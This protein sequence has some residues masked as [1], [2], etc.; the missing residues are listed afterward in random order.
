MAMTSPVAE[1]DKWADLPRRPTLVD[2][3]SMTFRFS[4]GCDE[5]RKTPIPLDEARIPP[6]IFCDPSTVANT[7]LIARCAAQAT[8]VTSISMAWDSIGGGGARTNRTMT[9]LA[10]DQTHRCLLPIDASTF[11]CHASYGTP[12]TANDVLFE[13]TSLSATQ[14]R[15]RCLN[16]TRCMGYA[17]ACI[18]AG[19]DCYNEEYLEERSSS[20]SGTHRYVF[21]SRTLYATTGAV[22][23]DVVCERMRRAADVL[24]WNGQH[25]EAQVQHAS[26]LPGVLVPNITFEATFAS[27]YKRR[28]SPEL[29]AFNGDPTRAPSSVSTLPQQIRKRRW[30]GAQALRQ[31]YTVPE[32]QHACHGDTLQAVGIP[33]SRDEEWYSADSLRTYLRGTGMNTALTGT[34]EF[35]DRADN[36]SSLQVRND[37]DHA[38]GETMLDV[39]MLVGVAPGAR[40]VLYKDGYNLEEN[41]DYGET[42]M[43][44]DV[45]NAVLYAH[46]PP[47]VLS[48]SWGGFYRDVVAKRYA[49][50]KY[51]ALA[52]MGVSVIM[53]S[54][55]QG[56]V[57]TM[58]GSSL[59]DGNQICSRLRP[60]V[61]TAY[62]TV[63]G[64][65][66]LEDAGPGASEIVCSIESGAGITSGGGFDADHNRTGFF[67]FQAT[68]VE[69]YLANEA[70]N[71]PSAAQWNRQGRAYPDV[72]ALAHNIG[73]HDGISG[74]TSAAAPMFAGM[75]SLVNDILSSQGKPL[76]G[77]LA[78]KLYHV[79]TH[80]PD[81]FL[82]T[83]TGSNRCIGQSSAATMCCAE[84]FSA[85]AG[86]DPATGLGTPNW[87]VLARHLIE[88][89]GG[90]A[91]EEAMNA[92]T[93]C[94][95]ARDCGQLGICQGIASQEARCLH[96]PNVTHRQCLDD[97]HCDSAARNE[98]AGVLCTLEQCAGGVTAT[99]SSS[100]CEIG[101]FG[102]CC[103][104]CPG[105]ALTPC[106]GHGNCTGGDGTR[107]FGEHTPMSAGRCDCV[108]GFTGVACEISDPYYYS[109]CDSS[110]PVLRCEPEIPLRSLADGEIVNGTTAGALDCVGEQSPEHIFT[111]TLASET[112]VLFTFGCTGM[113]T[114]ISV[115]TAGFQ[116]R[117]LTTTGLSEQ[118]RS[119]PPGQYL[120]VVEGADGVEGAYSFAL[121]VPD[122]DILHCDQPASLWGSDCVGD[123]V[124]TRRGFHAPFDGLYTIIVCSDPVAGPTI[125]LNIVSAGSVTATFVQG[126]QH[127]A[128]HTSCTA[129]NGATGYGTFATVFLHEGRHA[130][131]IS[132]ASQ[133]ASVSSAE[134]TI[135][136]SCMGFSGGADVI[137]ALACGETHSGSMANGTRCFDDSTGAAA[138]SSE[139]MFTID[140]PAHVTVA[141]QTCNSSFNASLRVYGQ[142]FRSELSGCNLD[143]S[144]PCDC[145][146]GLSQPP[147]SQGTWRA[148]EQ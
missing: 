17:R 101:F 85:A 121:G 72:S 13:S 142:G 104:P 27:G 89:Q 71:L 109:D 120:V 22:V 78:P 8:P 127:R 103:L 105:G 26:L 42:A 84:G 67:D 28:F 81:A 77:W 74:G 35:E 60:Q 98:S 126:P 24:A 129:S 144:S 80:H 100:A 30:I 136:C 37:C 21:L 115:F 91:S 107:G 95:A 134:I 148:H 131:A 87:P 29:M 70:E 15:A 96:G 5:F 146:C 49:D 145:G 123:R 135:G 68:Q 50:N 44:M 106:S 92:C 140:V 45:V 39:E 33:T 64:G 113:A 128:R 4:L 90:N 51:L 75:M 23:T 99:C 141:I 38:G 48:I 110:G 31:V 62:A 112:M 11:Y 86:W 14:A 102:P 111:L 57:S 114:S 10:C 94:A 41:D 143:G 19:I 79:H 88:L 73:V 34:V 133:S 56:A 82:D 125:N 52:L 32:R 83:T 117:K 66:M 53:S 12:W 130:I 93:E 65:T 132:R 2:T 20:V 1:Y 137:P 55:D 119:L 63:V 116:T 139:R 97:Q 122:A 147:A 36:A 118:H 16:D 76:L 108:R 47:S 40:T 6:D 59:N 18:T 124:S 46:R 7:T 3:T 69:A 9:R 138:A 61:F 54:G 43:G 58:F 25:C